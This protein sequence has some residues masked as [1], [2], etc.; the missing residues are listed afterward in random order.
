[1]PGLRIAP[2]R[3]CRGYNTRKGKKRARADGFSAPGAR[4]IPGHGRKA[5][6][7]AEMSNMEPLIIQSRSFL[8]EDIRAVDALIRLCPDYHWV[9]SLVPGDGG[10][11]ERLLA[12]GLAKRVT[13]A[14][15]GEWLLYRFAQLLGRLRFRRLQ[16]RLAERGVGR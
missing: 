8:P 3:E 14:S 11:S 4:P 7:G 12:N 10:L 6:E 13:P 5:D 2:C 15:I 16:R 1:M 9:N